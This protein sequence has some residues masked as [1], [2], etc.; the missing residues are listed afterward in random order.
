MSHTGRPSG[1]IRSEPP[2]GPWYSIG[3]ESFH[4]L[5]TAAASKSKIRRTMSRQKL[6]EH[7]VK[8]VPRTI[9]MK[10]STGAL[11]APRLH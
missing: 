3:K 7:I 4:L 10:A 2:I 1:T 6:M 8:L 11:G 5:G 9:P